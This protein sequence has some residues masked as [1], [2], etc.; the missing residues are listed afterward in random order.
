MLRWLCGYLLVVTACPMTCPVLCFSC[1][2]P[3]WDCGFCGL[4]FP[5]VLR[6]PGLLCL[7]VA[8]SLDS[9]LASAVLEGHVTGQLSHDICVRKDT[10]MDGKPRTSLAVTCCVHV[11]TQLSRPAPLPLLA[12]GSA[13]SAGTTSVLLSPRQALSK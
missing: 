8:A 11:L 13:H 9:A 12:A 3:C 4:W 2:G 6:V 10:V 1:A 5:P 7:P